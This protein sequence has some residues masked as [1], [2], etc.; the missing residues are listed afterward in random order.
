MPE[1]S[2]QSNT[3]QHVFKKINWLNILIGVVIGVALL[4][5]GYLITYNIRQTK[6]PSEEPVVVNKKTTTS[7]GKAVPSA[8][9]PTP[10]DK[11]S[12]PTVEKDKANNKIEDK[13]YEELNKKGKALVI[14]SLTAK[15][16]VETTL[17]ELN[18][19]PDE[20][21]IVY[22]WDSTGQFSGVVYKEPALTKLSNHSKVK[23]VQLDEPVPPTT[24]Q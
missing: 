12:T 4:S 1:A 10:A 24:T 5:G 19:T 6:A 2:P 20:F 21:T 14:V 17:N 23:A 18:F 22:K 15:E 9:E 11:E 13:V 7:T 3:S 16:I 8:Q